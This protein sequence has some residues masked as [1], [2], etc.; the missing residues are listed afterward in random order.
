[1]TDLDAALREL[2]EAYGI[3][4]EFWDW[5]GQH[6]AVTADTIIKVLEALDVDASTP[7]AAGRAL[8]LSLIHI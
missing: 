4:I 1:M 3:A 2:A 8:A 6:V 5:Q 7:E